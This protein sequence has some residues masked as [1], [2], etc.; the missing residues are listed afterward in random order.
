MLCTLDQRQESGHRYTVFVNSTATIGSIRTDTM[1]PGQHFAVATMEVCSRIL[2]SENEITICWATPHHG[3]TGNGKADEYAKAAADG[4]D[5]R[6]AAPDEYR[7][8]TSLSH[9]S[10]V[11]T[12]TRSHTTVD[13]ISSR[14]G[15]E[16][17]YCPPPERGFRR[18][19]LRRMRKSVDG[20]YY[21][22][23]S[24]HVAIGPYLKV[25]FNRCELPSEEPGAFLKGENTAIRRRV[26]AR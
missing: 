14:V 3:V 25:S 21:Q 19:Q 26:R 8:E 18:Q 23:L 7:W 15:P 22:L 24:G 11:A 5:L 10:R 4:E 16:R 20:R 17:R 2:E 12:E 6:D 1:G 9:M 13:G